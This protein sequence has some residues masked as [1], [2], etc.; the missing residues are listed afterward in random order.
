M[1]FETDRIDDEKPAADREEQRRDI[2][3]E[4]E[5]DVTE[6]PGFD[7]LEADAADAADQR[8]EVPIEEDRPRE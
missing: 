4:P 1:S 3:E 2:E 6:P 8:V 7:D 5:V